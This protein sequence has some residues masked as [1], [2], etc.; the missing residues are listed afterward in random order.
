MRISVSD[1]YFILDY[2]IRIRCL[3]DV[4]EVN[5]SFLK[6]YPENELLKSRLTK[7]SSLRYS[8]NSFFGSAIF[9]VEVFV[10]RKFSSHLQFNLRPVRLGV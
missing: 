7:K 4:W 8:N 2:K 9:E 10:V 1:F 5:V 3:S 6:T